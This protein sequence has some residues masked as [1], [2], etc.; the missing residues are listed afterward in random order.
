MA[1]FDLD[2]VASFLAS[3]CDPRYH[4]ADTLAADLAADRLRLIVVPDV[5]GNLAFAL[6]YALTAGGED[7]D[8]VAMNGRQGEAASWTR[9]MLPLVR[10]V[11]KREGASRITANCER[12]GM[13]RLLKAEGFDV[14][15]T[16][17]AAE[18]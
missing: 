2:A 9:D 12:E 6:A 10:E 14:L 8:V 3:A 16:T 7:F 15:T 11:A 18:V 4:T 13:I 1:E 5:D 17:M